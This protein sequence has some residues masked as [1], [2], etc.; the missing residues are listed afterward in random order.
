MAS[1]INVHY[2]DIIAWYGG[3][4]PKEKPKLKAWRFLLPPSIFMLAPISVL[5]IEIWSYYDDLYLI[6]EGLM[7]P[8]AKFNGVL[9]LILF[10]IAVLTFLFCLG[11]YLRYRGAFKNGLNTTVAIAYDRDYDELV[12]LKTF[13]AY[14]FKSDQFYR[15]MIPAYKDKNGNPVT[16]MRLNLEFK[17]GNH[18]KKIKLRR[19]GGDLLNI[20][21]YLNNRRFRE[22]YVW[23]NNEYYHY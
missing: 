1:K 21:M 18:I 19:I 10:V 7:D 23:N 13:N 22:Q 2:T 5:A 4:G 20:A 11:V 3:D 16:V 9:P 17:V 8:P 6:E 12:V 15:C 14:R